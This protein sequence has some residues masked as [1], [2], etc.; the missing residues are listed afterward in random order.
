M[1]VDL[2]EPDGPM[3]AVNWPA[4]NS[5]SMLSRARISLSP[6]PY[7]LVAPMARAAGVAG[8]WWVV[9]AWGAVRTAVMVVVLLD[10]GLVRRP[11][12]DPV[13]RA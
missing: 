11:C 12:A 7:A 10:E 4:W 3:M 8:G 5:T 9:A 6:L 2:P 1:S 13:T